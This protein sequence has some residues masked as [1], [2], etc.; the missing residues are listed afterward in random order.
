MKKV[1]RILANM[2]F[3]LNNETFGLEDVA[4]PSIPNCEIIFEVGIAEDLNFNYLDKE[5]KNRLLETI[6]RSPF[7]VMDLFCIL[8]Y[9]KRKKSK[10]KALRFDYYLIRL[11]MFAQKSSI[12]I[13]IFHERG[14]MHVVPEEIASFI[15]KR[16]NKILQRRL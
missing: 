13:L 3:K 4:G 10:K 11:T 14:P 2:F 1:Q 16:T 5:E 9:Y 8:R 7:K 12:S 6:H 15:M